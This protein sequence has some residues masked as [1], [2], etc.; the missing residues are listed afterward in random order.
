MSRSS[1]VQSPQLKYS[2]SYFSYN[3]CFQVLIVFL[4][5]I[6]LS[7]MLLDLFSIFFESLY[8]CIYAI[9]NTNTIPLSPFLD[10]YSLSMS[11]FRCR[12]LRIV[13]NL[14]ILWSIC[15]SSS[16]VP[17]QNSPEYLTRGS[18]QVFI[19]LMKFLWQSLVSR[20]FLIL[21]RYSFLIFKIFIWL[22]QFLIFPTTCNFP[23]LQVFWCFLHLVDLFLPLF[24][25]HHFSLSVWYIFQYK[26]T[27]VKTNTSTYTNTFNF[28]QIP[29][30]KIWTPL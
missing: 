18:A 23:S 5:D 25:L 29:L 26:T 13:I 7:L 1:C 9:F 22:C 19:P 15:L 2:Y 28:E 8:W 24:L 16:L 30:G 4:F 27:W 6:M 20:S 21:L 12:D 11:S 14:F 10:T 3:S 17:F